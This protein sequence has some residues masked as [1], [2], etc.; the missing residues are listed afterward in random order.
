MKFKHDRDAKHWGIPPEI[1]YDATA[2]AK[3]ERLVR[4]VDMFS[5]MMGW[6]EIT[7]TSFFRPDDK[8]SYHSILQAVD[9][10]TRDKPAEF[11][12]S[13][14]ILRDVLKANNPELQIYMHKELWGKPNQH[15][16][17]GI[18]DGKLKHKRSH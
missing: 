5:C 12:T 1:D 15:I 7:I 4:W 6:G 9:I 11:L 8:K 14:V 3:L 18:K 17:L 13:M 16:H 2:L 10:R